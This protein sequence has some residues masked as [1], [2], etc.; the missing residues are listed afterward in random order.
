MA[1]ENNP[2]LRAAWF[3]RFVGAFPQAGGM[4]APGTS[5]MPSMLIDAAVSTLAASNGPD[6]P[7]DVVQ[8]LEAL[9]LDLR[10]TGFPSQEYPKA[11]ETLIEAAGT[12]GLTDQDAGVLRAAGEVMARAAS[13]ADTAG[14]PPA[15]AAQVTSVDFRGAVAVVRAEAGNE[16]AYLPGQAVPVMNAARPGIWR[17]LAPALPA[18]ALGQLEFHIDTRETGA[19]WAPE[20]GGYLTLGQGRGPVA[21][22]DKPALIVAPG[23]GL[24]AAKALVFDLV[25]REE[26]VDVRLIVGAEHTEDVYD[27][28]TFA[29]LAAAHSW[30]DVTWVVERGGANEW[31][32]AGLPEHVRHLHAPLAQVAAGPGAWWGREVYVCGGAEEVGVVAEGVRGAGAELVVKLALA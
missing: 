7:A 25:E 16:V 22:V 19:D 17:A 24:A 29:A 6:L 2:G 23:T 18:N 14:V 31:A 5:Q 10:R 1:L 8:R 4:F 20:V 12:C 27:V 13:A 32:A 26:R 15:T 30:L 9:A 11:A 28:H 3:E 21:R